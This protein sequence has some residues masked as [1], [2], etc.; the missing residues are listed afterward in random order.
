MFK[1]YSNCDL[2]SVGLFHDILKTKDYTLLCEG[3][4]EIDLQLESFRKM[5]QMSGGTNLKQMNELSEKLNKLENDLKNLINKRPSL[6]ELKSIFYKI[7]EEYL[8]LTEDQSI[9][10]YLLKQKELTYLTKRFELSFDMIKE[11]SKGK[12]SDTMRLKYIKELK[13]WGYKINIKKDLN[14]EL[15]KIV[16][17]HKSSRV[18]IESKTKEIENIRKEL[19]ENKESIIQQ[20]ARLEQS[21]GRNYIDIYKTSL[22]KWASLIKLADE[23]YESNKKL[24]GK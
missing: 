3:Y 19:D 10:D 22:S 1:I 13:L 21:L 6:K 15:N 9:E 23:I 20:S 7:Y 11:L 8:I 17:Q 5:L 12:L 14:Q 18:R 24:N 2:I 16:N 4:A